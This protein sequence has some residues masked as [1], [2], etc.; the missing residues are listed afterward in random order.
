MRERMKKNAENKNMQK[1]MELAQAQL[2]AQQSAQTPE[3]SIDDIMA[4]LGPSI[5]E[6]QK[7]SVPK[8][9]NKNKK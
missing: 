5:E 3:L 7:P 9:K 2:R 1:A 6:K 8:K 4:S